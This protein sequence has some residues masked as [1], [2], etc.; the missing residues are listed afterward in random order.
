MTDKI[1]DAF[2]FLM[3]TDF[4]STTWGRREIV[5]S[6]YLTNIQHM[7]GIFSLISRQRN[8]PYRIE[9]TSVA[10]TGPDIG[11]HYGAPCLTPQ[12][13]LYSQKVERVQ[14]PLKQNN[15]LKTV[16]DFM[17]RGWVGILY[18]DWETRRFQRYSL[19]LA[20]ADY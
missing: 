18:V 9:Y 5:A 2:T 20:P 14:K 8:V 4:I 17:W 15:W 7:T 12:V 19:E 16:P 3:N 13:H 10:E 6:G 11:H 1:R